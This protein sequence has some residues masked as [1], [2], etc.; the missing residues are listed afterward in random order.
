MSIR[1]IYDD[2]SMNVK[3]SLRLLQGKYWQALFTYDYENA[4]LNK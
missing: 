3:E 2:G 1:N 4:A